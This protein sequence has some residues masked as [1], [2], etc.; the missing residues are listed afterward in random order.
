MGATASNK[1]T[2]AEH[3]S[4]STEHRTRKQNDDGR[5]KPG[6]HALFSDVP[7]YSFLSMFQNTGV[8]GPPSTPL[9]DLRQA[10]GVRY[11]PSGT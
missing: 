4:A 10:L 3:S 5:A 6:H 7:P 8:A 2:T 9:S 1:F 11:W